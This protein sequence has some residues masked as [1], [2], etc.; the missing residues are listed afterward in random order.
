MIDLSSTTMLFRLRRHSDSLYQ[1]EDLSLGST[2]LSQLQQ[3]I[4]WS[5]IS[6]LLTTSFRA[7][8]LLSTA[9]V[10]DQVAYPDIT[11][12]LHFGIVNSSQLWLS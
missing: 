3:M 10:E 9:L 7:L 12:C 6:W 1:P 11:H 4:P 5:K 8:G 2:Y